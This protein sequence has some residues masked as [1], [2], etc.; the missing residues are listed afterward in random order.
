MPLFVSILI[1]NR[2]HRNNKKKIRGERHLELPETPPLTLTA[3]L[4]CLHTQ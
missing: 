4:H 3:K 1:Y 2:Y